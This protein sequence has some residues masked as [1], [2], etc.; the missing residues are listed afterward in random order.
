MSGVRICIR[1]HTATN[2]KSTTVSHATAEVLRANGFVAFGIVD[3]TSGYRNEGT[4]GGL[5]THD[6]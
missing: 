2:H 3:G 6:L 1:K 5:M 4:G